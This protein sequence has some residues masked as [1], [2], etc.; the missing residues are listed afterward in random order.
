M[1]TYDVPKLSSGT[2]QLDSLIRTSTL[3]SFNVAR[4]SATSSVTSRSGRSGT[5][6]PSQP[7]PR[8]QTSLNYS[9]GIPVGLLRASKSP[10]GSHSTA[11][12]RSR[13]RSSSFCASLARTIGIGDLETGGAPVGPLAT[14]YLPTLEHSANWELQSGSA[15]H[16]TNSLVDFDNQATQISSTAAS[17]LTQL[18]GQLQQLSSSSAAASMKNPSGTESHTRK[19]SGEFNLPAPPSPDMLDVC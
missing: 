5:E 15:R 13:S 1:A 16:N 11:S 10:D 17:L 2:N 12:H 6:P 14:Q 9:T 7:H 3:T 18:S 19:E 8:P 4:S